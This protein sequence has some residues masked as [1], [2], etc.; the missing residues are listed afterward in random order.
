MARMAGT[1]L[2]MRHSAGRRQRRRG[3][4]DKNTPLGNSGLRSAG[5]ITQREMII[6]VIK[7]TY[8]VAFE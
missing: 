2:W 6:A 4:T 3:A 7:I 5:K 8:K 1:P